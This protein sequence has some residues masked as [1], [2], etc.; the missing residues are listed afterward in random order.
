MGAGQAYRRVIFHVASVDSA[1]NMHVADVWESQ[2][3][4]DE[5][6]NK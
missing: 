2:Q 6:L 1:G 3:Q 5:F 4:L